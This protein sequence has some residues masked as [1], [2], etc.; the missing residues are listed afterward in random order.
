MIDSGAPRPDA[1]LLAR[2]PSLDWPH[3][4]VHRLGEAGAFMVTAGILGK[5]HLL[6]TPAR[7]D[8]VLSLLF[9]CASEFGWKLQAWAVMS[10]HCHF[11]ALSPD[12]PGNLR[13]ML[14]KLHGATALKLNAM[15]GTPGRK[16]FYQYWDTHI[17]FQRSYLARLNY[18]HQN[19]VHHGIVPIALEYRRCSAA[20][21]ER[22][23]RPSFVRSLRRFKTD[24]VKVVE[25]DF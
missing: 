17:T 10:N 9:G 4:P 2:S 7:L 14:G 13:S 20:W 11:V 12:N 24:R 6:D 15:D 8:L 23:A 1:L 21:F 19:P 3:A 22:S 5:R 18:V 25:D 16:V